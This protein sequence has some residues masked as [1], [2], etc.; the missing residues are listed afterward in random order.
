LCSLLSNGLFEIIISYREHTDALVRIQHEQAEGAAENIGH[1]IKEIENQMGWTTQLT[2][3][4]STIE[5]RRFDGSRLL[6]PCELGIRVSGLTAWDSGNAGA[7]G[8]LRLES[9]RERSIRRRRHSASNRR[10]GRALQAPQPMQTDRVRL[11]QLKQKNAARGHA[12]EVEAVPWRATEA[13]TSRRFP[14]AWTVIEHAESFWVQDASWQTVG[15][16][17][18]RHNEET[19]RQRW[20]HLLI[21]SRSRR[22][23]R[24]PRSS[25]DPVQPTSP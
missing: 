7:S 14:A 23:K 1:F 11:D 22:R 2:W 19:A 16:F 5:Q 17:Y 20:V 3:S 18:F 25:P 10:S 4:A 6:R 13:I 12:G 9:D 15:W 8:K 21:P 24:W